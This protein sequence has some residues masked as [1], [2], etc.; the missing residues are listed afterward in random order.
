MCPI[1]CQFFSPIVNTK[2]LIVQLPRAA[3][4]LLALLIVA[5]GLPW[6]RPSAQTTG[7]R[8][9]PGTPRAPSA[10]GCLRCLRSALH[11]PPDRAVCLSRRVLTLTWRVWRAPSRVLAPPAPHRE[12]PRL[13][14]SSFAKKGVGMSIGAEQRVPVCAMPPRAYGCASRPH[15]RVLSFHS[16]C[17]IPP[18]D[19]LRGA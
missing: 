4:A 16:P 10:R 3:H 12:P 1:L 18:G 6:Q 7:R 8:R 11:L 9:S 14:A 19:D 13:D 17:R 5:A 15:C 2:L